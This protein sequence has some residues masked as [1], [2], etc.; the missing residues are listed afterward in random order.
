[1]LKREGEDRCFVVADYGVLEDGEGGRKACGEGQ[2]SRHIVQ[3]RARRLTLF[4]IDWVGYV[5]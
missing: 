5:S 4:L 3:D 1:M 2:G